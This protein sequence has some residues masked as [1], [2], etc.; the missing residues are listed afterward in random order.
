[1]EAIHK[2]ID[3]IM[4]SE[5]KSFEKQ[6]EEALKNASEAPPHLVWQNIEKELDKKNKRIV[7][8]FWL[9]KNV[10]QTGIAALLVL[11]LG[12]VIGSK[13]YSKKV[14]ENFSQNSILPKTIEKGNEN[15]QKLAN[16]GIDFEIKKSSEN[17]KKLLLSQRKETQKLETENELIYSQLA[18]NQKHVN[19]NEIG[20]L[21][22]I[23]TQITRTE[24]KSGSKNID[25]KLS[26]AF[27]INKIGLNQNESENPIASSNL[28]YEKIQNRGFKPFKNRFV[29]TR[30][31]LAYDSPENIAETKSKKDKIYLGFNSGLAPFNPNYVANSFNGDAIAS[32]RNDA[33]TA[34]SLKSMQSE[35]SASNF[36]PVADILQSSKPINEINAGRSLNLGFNVGKK[37]GK[38]I[39]W[40]SGVRLLRA[41]SS[42]NS[43]VYSIN[44]KSGEINSFFQTNYIKSNSDNQTIISL[45]EINTQSYNYINIPIQL[46]FNLPLYKSFGIELLGGFSNDFLLKNK[47]SGTNSQPKSLSS[48]NSNF[49]FMSLS[50]LGGLRLNYE[51]GSQWQIN[52][53]SNY[54]HAISSGIS[55]N[56]DLSFRPS[57]LGINYG[58]KYR[59]N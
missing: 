53:G 59:F 9:N 25:D 32:A 30:N 45:N 2:R 19:R 3:L 41:S 15:K 6:W 29:L 27:D 37:I 23:E 31:K 40:E 48:A 43:N 8:F 57:M 54:Q 47:F 35:T 4:E 11:T 51:L 44:E 50:G 12:Y 34:F 17:S 56:S 22:S 7:P 28:T 58:M 39:G 26:S 21:S 36:N 16:E 13:M 49:N 55:K 20:I 5:Q 1:M 52:L 18:Q 14:P 38:K 24:H 33:N 46:T 42:M 10:I